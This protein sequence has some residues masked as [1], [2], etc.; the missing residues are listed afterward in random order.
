MDLSTLPTAG[1]LTPFGLSVPRWRPGL[2]CAPHSEVFAN[3]DE[4]RDALDRIVLE[5]A[6]QRR[7]RR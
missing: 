5:F 7:D 1:E 3:G 6:R 4:A 2:P